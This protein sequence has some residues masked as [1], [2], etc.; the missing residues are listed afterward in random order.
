MTPPVKSTL[1]EN[2]TAEPIFK[3]YWLSD[4]GG[5]LASEIPILDKSTLQD[6]TETIAHLGQEPQSD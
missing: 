3:F 6:R 4:C 2:K 1:T 5:Y